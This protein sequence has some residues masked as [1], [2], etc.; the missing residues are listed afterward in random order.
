MLMWIAHQNF[1][2]SQPKILQVPV[3]LSFVG[4]F[5]ICSLKIMAMLYMDISN[6]L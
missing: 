2:T 4:G 5:K 1:E 3:G 6:N